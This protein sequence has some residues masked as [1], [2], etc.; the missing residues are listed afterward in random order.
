VLVTAPP[1][2][3]AFAEAKKI[4]SQV[5]RINGSDQ[6]FIL[7]TS[8]DASLT[9]SLRRALSQLQACDVVVG[10]DTG[11]MWAVAFEQMPKVVMLSNMPSDSVTKNWV[12]TITLH[13]DNE[14][15]PCYPCHRLHRDQST[16]VP[17][18]DN[19]GAKC[20][21]DIS[22]DLVVSTVKGVLEWVNTNST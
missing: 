13:A 5:A 9:W 14:R 19:T 7:A 11:P 10:P 16:C 3:D 8:P 2:P 20:I 12:H 22:I 1:F 6:G 17:N 15:V 21:S 4:M 18:A